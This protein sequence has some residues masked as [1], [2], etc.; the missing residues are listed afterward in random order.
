MMPG[1][2][3]EIFWWVEFSKCILALAF[4][5]LEVLLQCPLYFS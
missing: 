4:G 3:M 2:F 1:K 5:W